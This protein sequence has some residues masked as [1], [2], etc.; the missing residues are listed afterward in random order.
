MSDDRF[1][2]RRVIPGLLRSMP[3]APGAPRTFSSKAEQ[4]RVWMQDPILRSEAAS[5][6]AAMGYELDFNEYGQPIDFQAQAE[7]ESID[8]TDDPTRRIA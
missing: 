6:A 2:L 4:M 8:E 7:F 3:S 1:F 5:W